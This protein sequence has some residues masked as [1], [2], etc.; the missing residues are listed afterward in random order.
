MSNLGCLFEDADS[1]DKGPK[2][3]RMT[4]DVAPASARDELRE[5]LAEEAKLAQLQLALQL[6]HEENNL[7]EML[8][9]YYLD[10]TKI[11]FGDTNFSCYLVATC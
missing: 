9:S 6:Q 10:K 5:L 7:A 11:E 3:K 8:A 1:I 4:L 2:P